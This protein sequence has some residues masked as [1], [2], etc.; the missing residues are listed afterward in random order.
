MALRAGH[1]CGVCGR[2]IAGEAEE[3]RRVCVG[4]SKE[5]QRRQGGPGQRDGK[6]ADGEAHGEG[7][8]RAANL[9]AKFFGCFDTYL[10][11]IH[12]FKKI[13]A[14]VL[15]SYS[16]FFTKKDVKIIKRTRE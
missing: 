5:R 11:F 16:R 14:L 12:K 6:V 2:I 4:E 8:S 7:R 15:I 9:I 3:G 10:F 13:K 1:R